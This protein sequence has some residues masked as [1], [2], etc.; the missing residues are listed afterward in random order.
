MYDWRVLDGIRV[1]S[2]TGKIA[3]AIGLKKVKRIEIH[4]V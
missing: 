3:I 2:R 4:T 1:C